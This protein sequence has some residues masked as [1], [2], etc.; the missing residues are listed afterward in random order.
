M[1]WHK[2][3]DDASRQWKTLIQT[4]T[5]YVHASMSLKDDGF[6]THVDVLENFKSC[7]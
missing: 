4:C 5:I 6:K 2:T 7:T 3:D 1:Y